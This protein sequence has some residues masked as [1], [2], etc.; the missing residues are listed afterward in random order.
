MKEVPW[1]FQ[2]TYHLAL[3]R[4]A[5]IFLYQLAL[6]FILNWEVEFPCIVP[7]LTIFHKVFLKN[8]LLTKLI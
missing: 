8:N 5:Q 4:S 2:G 7:L 6:I 1:S 3:K